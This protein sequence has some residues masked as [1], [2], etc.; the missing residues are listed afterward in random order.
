MIHAGT[1]VIILHILTFILIHLKVFIRYACKFESVHR[2][3]PE[4]DFE[5]VLF[6]FISIYFILFSFVLYSL[7]CF[8]LIYVKNAESFLLV[9]GL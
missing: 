9:L 5:N 1:D 6:Y 2:K 7:F 4:P 8:V 3:V